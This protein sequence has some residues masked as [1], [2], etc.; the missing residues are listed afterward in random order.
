[1]ELSDGKVQASIGEES[2]ILERVARIIS[3]VRGAKPDYAHLAAELEPALPFDIF[4]IVLL[5]HDR[6]AVR[7]TVCQKSGEN[8]V[9]RYLQHPLA[10]SMVGRVSNILTPVETAPPGEQEQTVINEKQ[11]ADVLLV[12]DFPGGLTGLPSE[13]GDA[14]CAYPQ[15]QAVLIAPLIAGGNFLGTL[16][17]GSTQRKAYADLTLQRLIHAIA[18][19]LATAIEGAQVGG[20]VEIQNRQRAELKDVSAVLTTAVDVPMILDRIVAGITN[21]LHVASAIVRL[22][23]RQRRLR[24]EAY[25]GLES[26]TL[27]KVLDQHTVLSEQTIIGK[28]LL[29]RQSQV[30]QDI[31]ADRQ[32]P[33]SQSF[34]SELAVRSIFCYPLNTGQYVYG[35]L[36]LLSPETGG[37]TP[38]KTDI[39]S[40]FAGQAT[41]AIQNGILLQS[42]QERR[43]FQESIEQLERANQQNVFA[44]PD[45]LAESE[46]LHRLRNESMNTFGVSLSSILRFIGDHLLTRS[47][48]HLQEILR[49]LNAQELPEESREITDLWTSEQVMSYAESAT[50]LAH[51]SDIEQFAVSS[52][53]EG[54]ALLMQAADTA[55][56][57]TDFLS[58]ISAALTRALHVD[59]AHP[60]AYEHL[61]RQLAEPWFIVDLDGTCMYLNRAAEVFCGLRETL[62][63]PYTWQHWPEESQA[64]FSSFRPLLTLKEEPL[65]LEQ[66]LDAILPRMRQLKE[67]LAYLH[68]F[69]V[70]RPAGANATSEGDEE[71]VPAFLRCTVAAEPLPGQESYLINAQAGTRAW[72]V[73]ESA[74]PRAVITPPRQR[75][76]GSPMLLD[77]SPS[78]RHYQFIRHALYN[79]EGQWFAN[80]LHIHDITE[81]VRDEKNKSVLLASVS[82]DLRTPLTTIKA[83]V[84][85]L[86]Q[87]GVEW[88]DEMRREILE[89]IDAETDHLHTLVN[90]LVEMS[91]IEMGA[92]V[93]EKEWCDVV[94]LVH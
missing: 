67:V 33:L 62:H 30:S 31:E 26:A 13:C 78:D 10:D 22:D 34:A 36:L 28:T 42:A 52:G 54:T 29:S 55:L 65:T 87:P 5:R 59:E 37:F 64:L 61:K 48:R 81:Q 91:R 32:F 39:F 19:V 14:L 49:S 84:T 3:S 94:E 23:S 7:V 74:E 8:W 40:L 9:A 90:A 53:R 45:E 77:S 93:L 56:A 86:L 25:S 92:L 58:D 72:S 70:T 43:R 68:D 2:N 6:E 73:A 51:V 35:A 83:A 4:G 11:V 50:V 76:S 88:G 17:L 41:V 46:L 69:I 24:L 63:G 12:Q 66:A 75:F 15:L 27:Q 47:E 79:E 82:H 57:S 80:A 44:S 71:T 18:R 85:G 21:A 89:D 38:L 16:E 1:M 20:N 60:Q